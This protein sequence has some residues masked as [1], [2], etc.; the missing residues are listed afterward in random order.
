MTAS[1]AAPEIIPGPVLDYYLSQGYYRMH[2]D[3][4][5][6]QFLPIAG[7]FYTVHWLRVVLAEVQFGPAQRRLLR[8]NEQFTSTLRPFRL[9]DEYENLYA[10][11]RAAIDFDAPETVEAFTLAGARHNAFPSGVIELR[12]GPRLIA[13]G[14]FDAGQRSLAGIMNFYDPDY[15]RHSLGKYLM[16]L[17]IN[18]ARQQGMT[19]YYPGYLVQGYPKF[20]YKLFA[21]PAATEVFDSMRGYWLP[22]NWAAVNHH[23]AELLT[24]W[25]ERENEL[26]DQE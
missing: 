13:V 2:Q 12:D 5:T 1:S 7:G 21:G 8:L 18:F 6:C 3:L 22:F 19:H 15:R 10:R 25:Q 20:D 14:I 24:A 17:K 23:S 16:L 9:S 4:F 11:Y 26:E